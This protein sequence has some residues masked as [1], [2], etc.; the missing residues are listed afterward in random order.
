MEAENI[1]SA[2]VLSFPRKCK[3]C[4]ETKFVSDFHKSKNH[5]DGIDSRCKNCHKI[6][7]AKWRS[8][9]KA[10]EKA[11]ASIWIKE[12]PEKVKEKYR[13]YASNN[14]DRRRENHKNWTRKNPEKV[15]KCRK[16]WIAKNPEKVKLARKKYADNWRKNASPEKKKEHSIKYK[17][18]ISWENFLSIYLAQDGKCA[19]CKKEV[20]QF[21]KKT[22]VDHNH[23]TGR[24]RGILCTACNF[25]IGAL[26]EKED[27][28]L[29]AVK[30]LAKY[31]CE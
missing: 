19:I 22:C 6:R 17:Y 20:G 7:A 5:K 28:L 30:Y 14:K 23:T 10:K 8:E 4:G 24:V 15:K 27:N 26:G 25:A 11:S 2:E 12:N 9:N 21:C 29:E 1:K 31:R 3:K 16:N 18:G 13:R